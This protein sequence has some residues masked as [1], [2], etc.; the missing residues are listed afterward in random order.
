VRAAGAVARGEQ[1]VT[2][3]VSERNQRRFVLWRPTHPAQVVVAGF[4]LAIVTGTALLML[5]V[6]TARPGGTTLLEA[7]FTA[8]SAV[9]VTGL[10]VVDT[11]THWS[12]FGKVVIL[13]L[14]Q[15]GGLGIMTFASLIGLFA[16]GRLGLRARMTAAAETRSLRLGDTR[17]VLVG[18][19]RISV[20]VEVVVAVLLAVRFAWHYDL[21]PARSVWYGI[22]H[23]VSGFNNAGFALFPDS[24]V[25]YAGDAWIVVPIM[26]AVVIGGLGFPVV[27][28]VVRWFRRTAH[29]HSGGRNGRSRR[30]WSWSVH[31][32]LA[33][34][35]TAVLLVGGAVFLGAVEWAN[36]RTLGALGVPERVMNAVALSVMPRTAGFNT[37][38]VAAMNPASWLGTDFLM[39]IGGASAGTAGGV[40]VT[41]VAVLLFIVYTELRGEGAVNVFNRRLPR[42]MQ[43]Q[44]LTIVVLASVAVAASTAFL[45]LVTE[46]SLDKVLFEVVSAFGTVGLSTGITGSLPVVGQLLLTVLMFVGRLGPVAVASS[47]VMRTRTRHHELPKESPI[48]G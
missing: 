8:T 41:T 12:A 18:V 16:V 29:V 3:V 10:V 45:L 28:E 20:A 11:A 4:A 39:F 1:P 19:I 7:L 17:S 37:I 27:F 24:L 14:I 44:A 32:R 9:C 22:F 13:V 40:K 33:V 38:D 30:R 43:R 21:S 6:A 35:L 47:L 31:T 48:I 2:G 46:F 23:S 42:S 15:I 26:A 5:P 36:P 25:R 34:G